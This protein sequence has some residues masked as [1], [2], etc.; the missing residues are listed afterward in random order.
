MNKFLITLLLSTLVIPLTAQKVSA[1][2]PETPN[3]VF[4]MTDDLGYGDLGCYGQTKIKTPRLDQMAK[5]GKRFTRHYSGNT[6]CAPAR[7]VLM[8]GKHTGHCWIRGNGEIQPNGQRPIPKEEITVAEVLKEKGY[9]TGCIGK[10]GLGWA[11]S[12]GQP[13]RQGFDHFFG[14]LCQRRAHTYY[15][16][17]VWRNM[18]KVMLPGNDGSKG[19]HYTHDLMTEEALTFI[20]TNKNKPFFLYVPYTIPHTKFQVPELGQ[21]EDKPWKK[22]HK[23]QAAMISRMD[24]DCGRILDL[25]DELKLSKNTLVIFTSDNGA[26]GQSGTGNFFKSSGKLRGIKRD[27][28]EGGIRVPMIARWPGKVEAG[29]TSNHSSAFWDW[30]PTLCELTNAK[31]P[32]NIDGISILPEI[33]GKAGQKTHDHFYWEFYEKGGK[34]AILKGDLKAIRLNVNK[35]RFGPLELYNLADDESETNNIA[36]QHPK[37]IKEMEELMAQEH[38]PSKLFV[39][40]QKKKKRNNKKKTVKK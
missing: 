15:P 19:P 34:Q 31:A 8:T 38:V 4:I 25:L 32:S 14:Y 36:S 6:V 2:N 22:E 13:N 18:D 20:K 11:D 3:I 37:I 5:E 29:T 35:K 27:L 33:L 1:K 30:M 16:E 10:W 9:T 17:Y 7:C 12:E 39:F 28:Y 26:H 40:G 24:R 23:I 21:Y